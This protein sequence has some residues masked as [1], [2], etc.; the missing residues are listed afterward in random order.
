MERIAGAVVRVPVQGPGE[1][2]MQ[3]KA[4]GT[5]EI[6]GAA[7]ERRPVWRVRSDA[8]ARAGGT[9][10]RSWFAALWPRRQP[11]LYQRCLAV[12][13]HYAGPRSALS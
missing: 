12:H 3:D 4:M 2:P 11:T 8:P 9:G 7:I 6:G 10:A 5:I 13:I 1:G